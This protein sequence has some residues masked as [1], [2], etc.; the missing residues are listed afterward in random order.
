MVARGVSGLLLKATAFGSGEDSGTGRKNRF[1]PL[2]LGFLLEPPRVLSMK[3]PNARDT[4][5]ALVNHPLL[6]SR[7]PPT[8]SEETCPPGLFPS[9]RQ[10]SFS[11]CLSPLIAESLC[12]SVYGLILSAPHQIMVEKW[13][14]A[15]KG[16]TPG[17]LCLPT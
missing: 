7:Q 14:M 13:Y 8:G 17:L 16:K 15:G 10:S 12:F 2:C 9:A 4:D 1:Q 11:L 6:F 5:R 3:P